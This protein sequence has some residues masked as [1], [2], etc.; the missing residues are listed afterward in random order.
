MYICTNVNDPFQEHDT[1]LWVERMI[2]GMNNMKAT[3]VLVLHSSL[4]FDVFKIVKHVFGLDVVSDTLD[5]FF[6]DVHK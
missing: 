4:D 1:E 3:L 5:G 6:T 2:H